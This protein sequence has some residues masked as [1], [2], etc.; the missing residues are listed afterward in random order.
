MCDLNE[1][2]DTIREIAKQVSKERVKLAQALST[3][4]QEICDIQHYM[5]FYDFSASKGFK[6]YKML[7]ERLKTR[8]E[9]KNNITKCT[10]MWVNGLG[11]YDGGSAI[12][13]Y[14]KIDNQKYHA[15]VLKELFNDQ[16][17]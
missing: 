13:S 5:E 4:D 16:I 7:Q 8:R 17:T 2:F 10:I 12:N 11:K 15:R 3:V 9:I 1:S 14:R 6:A